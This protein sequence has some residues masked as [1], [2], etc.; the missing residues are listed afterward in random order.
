[1]HIVNTNAKKFGLNISISEWKAGV[2]LKKFHDFAPN[3]QGVFHPAVQDA[4]RDNNRVLVNPYGR[5]RQFFG[6]W[7]DGFFKEGYA[8]IP[9]SS[10]PDHF[11]KAGMR[12]EKRLHK[13]GLYRLMT[14]FDSLFAIEAHNAFVALI[15]K[16]M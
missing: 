15:R 16:Q 8:H 13:E 9:Q 2:I 4:L 6:E 7:G 12:L 5:Y 1:M 3:I 11:R 14:G 10:V